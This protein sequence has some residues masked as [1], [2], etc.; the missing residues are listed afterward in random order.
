MRKIVFIL[1]IFFAFL[2]GL[3]F[4]LLPSNKNSQLPKIFPT[5]TAYPAK[6]SG[7]GGQTISYVE[8]TA[9]KLVSKIEN[10]SLTQNAQQIKDNLE[11]TAK[12]NDGVLDTSPLYVMRFIFAFQ[13]VQVEILTT[14]ISSAKKAAVGWLESQGLDSKSICDLPVMFYLTAEVKEQITQTEP[15]DYL[16]EGCL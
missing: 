5:P 13:L 12:L 8:G 11:S 7:I 1:I 9:E 14:D 16:P 4:I 3:L 10:P 15:F 2:L 6:T